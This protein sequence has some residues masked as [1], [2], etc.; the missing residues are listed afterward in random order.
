MH[1][2]ARRLTA[3]LLGLLATPFLFAAWKDPSPDYAA[4]YKT[5]LI[6][7][8]VIP[9]QLEDF[10]QR[11]APL[12]ELGNNDFFGPGSI[13]RGHRIPTGAVWQ[14]QFIVFGEFRSALQMIENNQPGSPNGTTVNEWV[15]RADLVG[16]LYL[17]PTE[18][19]VVGFDPLRQ[20]ND[21][22]ATR[23]FG[24][25]DR[26][27][28][29]ENW[30]TSL[31]GNIDTFFFEG[32]FGSIF[33]S[34][35]PTD[36]KSLDYHFTVG[37][38]PLFLQDGMLAAGP[39]DMVGVTRA[40]TYWL[41]SN[42]TRATALYAWGKVAHDNNVVDNDAR[43]YGIS[44]AADYNKWLVEGDVLFAETGSPFGGGFHAGLGVKGQ[45]DKVNATVRALTSRAADGDS[46]QVSTGSLLF[47]QLSI[48]QPFTEN[49][50]YLNGFWGV[51]QFASAHR[52]P[53]FGGPLGQTGILFAAVGMGRFTPA[54][55]NVADDAY[56][57]GFGWQIYFDQEKRSQLVLETGFR[58]RKDTRASDAYGFAARYQQAFG[59][60]FIG[61]VEGYY[62]ERRLLDGIAGIRTELRVKF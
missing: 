25:R 3:S 55:G 45:I 7:D 23:W 19:F 33:R 6:T 15:N 26:P 42:H 13:P 31:D 50:I 27:K 43:F 56:G 38:Q 10:P 14:P 8:E 22:G 44:V 1:P 30:N 20:T 12:L 24:Y 51:D 41:G 46:P 17:T 16:V 34:L 58:N 35:D 40:S 37:R 54:L 29:A 52:A 53:N 9:L 5:P 21:A 39:V 61:L 49:V 47:T 18:R 11:P 28:G 36:T 60:R 62:A 32:D 4:G 48:L 59:T 2:F 57:A